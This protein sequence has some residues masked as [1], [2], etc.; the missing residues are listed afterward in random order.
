MGGFYPFPY[1]SSIIVHC[2]I[3]D[4]EISI[5]DIADIEI[6]DVIIYDI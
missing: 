6:F 2:G 4:F 5:I 1:W 3:F